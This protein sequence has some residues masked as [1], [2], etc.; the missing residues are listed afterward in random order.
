MLGGFLLFGGLVARGAGAFAVFF[1][2]MYGIHTAVAASIVPLLGP[3]APIFWVLQALTILNLATLRAARLRRPAWHWLIAWPGAFFIVATFLSI[4]LLPALWWPQATWVFVLPFTLAALGLWWSVVPRQE[5]VR[6]D[7]GVPSRGDELHRHNPM[8]SRQR[9]LK[10]ARLEGALRV[11]Q[12]TDP[13]LGPF[14]S[15]RRLSAILQRAVDLEPDLIVLTGDLLTVASQHHPDALR[16]SLA[17]L[18]AHPCVYACLGN[19]D[20]EAL[21]IVQTALTAA[22]VRLLIDEEAVAETSWGPVQVI[23]IDFMWRDRAARTAAALQGL[24]HRRTATGTMFRLVLLHDPGM[25]KHVPAGHADLVLSGHTHG[26]Q[27]G[28]VALGFDWTFVGAVSDVP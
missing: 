20:H 2:V 25:F 17:P 6:L 24:P 7:L 5:T 27:V 4:P 23:G 12:V 9:G 21:P 1:I 10:A 15:V 19:H 11:V 13:H 8:Q 16:T 26:G 18:R 3:F 14:M 28:L 22:G